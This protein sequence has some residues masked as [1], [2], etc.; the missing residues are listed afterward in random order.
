MQHHRF[1]LSNPLTRI[2]HLFSNKYKFSTLSHIQSHNKKKRCFIFPGMGSQYTGMCKDLYNDYKYIKIF[3]EECDELLG[4]SIS[5]IMFNAEP[6][7]LQQ[8]QFSGTS[9]FIHSMCIWKILE[10]E[11]NIDNILCDNNS[12]VI[13][14][15]TGEYSALTVVNVFKTFQDA[16]H[17]TN[18]YTQCMQECSS[19]N[20][21]MYA[22]IS[23]ND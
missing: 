20:Q 18:F 1:L 16:L 14:H 7:E 11:Y 22:I 2:G 15:S 6:K 8:P 12:T 23:D 17:I 13:G 4:F 3:L 10:T 19:S 5:N 9:I 21:A